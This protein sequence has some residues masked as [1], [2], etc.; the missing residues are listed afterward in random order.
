MAKKKK[1]KSPVVK[2]VEAA[3]EANTAEAP[4]GMRRFFRFSQLAVGEAGT[5]RK[6]EDIWATFLK[7]LDDLS[8]PAEAKS[9]LESLGPKAVLGGTKG[10]P[11]SVTA[12]AGGKDNVLLLKETQAAARGALK[13][14]SP[15]ALKAD[16][17]H[18]ISQMAKMDE[19][20][21][22]NGRRIIAGLRKVDPKVLAKAGVGNTLSALSSRGDDPLITQLFNKIMKRPGTAKIP[23][24]ILDTLRD[25][26]NGKLPKVT[27]ATTKAL[28]G[29]GVSGL[30]IGRKIAGLAGRSKVGGALALGVA[31][32]EVA[33][34]VHTLGRGKR[35]KQAALEGFQE[36]GPTSSVEF[37]R[38][39]V[40]KQEVAARR[41]VTLQRFEPELF[42]EAI[43]IL[44][45][46][47]ASKSTLTSTERRIG[48]DERMGAAKSGRDPEDVQ[49]LVDQ[50][51]SQMGQ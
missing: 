10:L 2:A 40:D 27:R 25:A 9:R 44:S 17:A 49:F 41:K 47:G 46:T 21:N 31:G 33:R 38:D 30:G 3:G 19:F 50:L 28:T 45:D 36:L 20:N 51:F 4:H 48:S 35:A 6:L 7:E 11:D 12:V 26:N 42:Q 39:I 8:I 32:F 16:L 18:A 15:R 1:K 24:G 22:A 29:A 23:T 14:L 13:G 37:L 43:R 5:T 34:N